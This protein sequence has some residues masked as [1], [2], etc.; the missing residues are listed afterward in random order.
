MIINNNKAS[1]NNT[2]SDSNASVNN[3]TAPTSNPSANCSE[4]HTKYFLCS[5][6]TTLSIE[7]IEFILRDSKVDTTDIKLSEPLGNFTRKETQGLILSGIQSRQCIH[8]DNPQ[9]LVTRRLN[10]ADMGKH[11][12]YYQINILNISQTR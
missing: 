9:V 11:R 3:N 2:I 6:E 12:D 4:K 1:G 7:D 5:I 10:M 8:K